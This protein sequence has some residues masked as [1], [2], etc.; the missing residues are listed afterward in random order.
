[1]KNICYIVGIAGAS[2]DF[3]LPRLIK[4]GKIYSLIAAPLPDDKINILREFCTDVREIPDLGKIDFNE[5]SLETNII[6]YAQEIS[7]DAILT[8]DEFSIAAV[9]RAAVKLNLRGAGVNVN[10]SRNKFLMREHFRKQGVP[11]PKYFK[12]TEESDRNVFLD[13]IT[14][15]FIIKVTEGAGSFCHT[16]IHKKELFNQEFDMLLQTVTQIGN[17]KFLGVVDSFNKPEFIAE[18]VIDA[19]TESWFDGNEYGNYVSV[20]GFVVNGVYKPISITSRLPTIPPFTETGLQTPCELP[21]SK[22]KLLEDMARRAVDAMELQFCGTHTE[23]KLLN[24]NNMC[25]IETAARLP[26]ASIT[27]MVEDSFGIDLIGTLAELLL[28]GSSDSIPNEMLDNKSVLATGSVALVPANASGTP[29]KTT[30]PLKKDIDL[31]SIIPAG[32]TYQIIWNKGLADGQDIPSY[33]L[34]KGY[35]N[36]LGGVYLKA[37]KTSDITKAQLSILNSL[38]YILNTQKE[39]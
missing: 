20:E 12:L 26:G 29:W 2:L 16:V 24:K 37:E 14:T 21:T 23:I 5:E 11:N 39:V 6:S 35:F 8:L 10:R 33:D 36:F 9:S 19:T 3:A 25:L 7:A 31:K 1:M 32:V 38:E 22:R 28:Y 18:E 13:A 30:P 15:P 27:A 17:D 34:K 4:K